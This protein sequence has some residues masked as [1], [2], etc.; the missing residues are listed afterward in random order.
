MKKYLSLLLSFA[1]LISICSVSALA[2]NTPDY[3]A[4][5][6]SL[7]QQGIPN[8][9]LSRRTDKQIEDLYNQC[10][11]HNIVFG[12]SEITYLKEDGSVVSPSG[13][14]P[15][16]DM[17]LEISPLYDVGDDG[18]GNNTYEACWMYV[19]YEWTSGHPKVRKVDAI[20]VNWDPDIWTFNGEFEHTDYSD[21]WTAYSGVTRPTERN[22]GGLGYYT[23][24]DPSGSNLVGDTQFTLYPATTPLYPAGSAEPHFRSE[25]NVNYVHDK[26]PIPVQGVSIS[27]EGIGIGLDFG[28]LADEASGTYNGYYKWEP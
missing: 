18:N 3:D 2:S 26:N 9:F 25:V 28:A 7:Q 11:G 24:L 19:Y 27:V 10:N 15:E 5:R 4:M 12:G 22:Q 21:K 17:I 8:N 14:I 13:A 6:T 20:A 16:Y 23:Y 1:M